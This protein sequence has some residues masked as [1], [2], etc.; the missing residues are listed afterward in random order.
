M[1]RVPLTSTST[2][3]PSIE[4]KRWIWQMSFT[5]LRSLELSV[6][7]IFMTPQT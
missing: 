6:V 5:D 2:L 3:L 7:N 1:A 4:Y